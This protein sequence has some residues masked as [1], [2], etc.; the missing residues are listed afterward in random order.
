[1]ADARV[2]ADLIFGQCAFQVVEGE[3]MRMVWGT[4]SNLLQTM[5]TVINHPRHQI[6][7]TRL[8]WTVT[9]T[10]L[11]CYRLSRLQEVEVLREE[12]EPDLLVVPEELC[13]PIH[14]SWDP[15]PL[16]IP[17]EVCVFV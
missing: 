5:L 4:L 15:R 7:G 10:V 1:M 9:P 8:E 12:E 13:R 11:R 6:P 3:Q 16:H 2:G 14:K 17:T